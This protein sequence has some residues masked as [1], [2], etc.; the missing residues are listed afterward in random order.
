ML[1]VDSSSYRTVLEKISH[2]HVEHLNIVF[3]M[4]DCG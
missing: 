3:N 2:S 4:N 1:Y